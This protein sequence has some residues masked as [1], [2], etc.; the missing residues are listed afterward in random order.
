MP[1]RSRSTSQGEGCAEPNLPSR[2]PRPRVQG[3]TVIPADP[4]ILVDL[5]PS[6][7]GCYVNARIEGPPDRLPR[8]YVGVHA[9]RDEAIREATGW[10]LGWLR[11]LR[12]AVKP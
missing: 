9:T 12:E 8:T 5:R 2:H 4:H 1:S 3:G 7:E 10:A 11:R 6:T